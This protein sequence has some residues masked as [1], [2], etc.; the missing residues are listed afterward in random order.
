MRM[1]G[2]VS[3]APS[4]PRGHAMRIVVL[5]PR[6][7]RIHTR[8]SYRTDVEETGRYQFNLDLNSGSDHCILK[9]DG[10]AL[11]DNTGADSDELKKYDTDGLFL[12]AGPKKLE[13]M[14]K[15]DRSDVH[16][17]SGWGFALKHRKW[18]WEKFEVMAPSF[19]LPPRMQESTPSHT[20]LPLTHRL[21]PHAPRAQGR[22][23]LAGIKLLALCHRKQRCPGAQPRRQ[24]N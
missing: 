23:H 11:V 21:A 1:A 6:I 9:V 17:D 7:H 10:V 19:F 12:N 16:R 2:C 22:S 20:C 5:L 4:N 3:D 18:E 8:H 13:L 14:Y 24:R 15:P